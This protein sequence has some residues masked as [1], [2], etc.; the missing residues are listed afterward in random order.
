MIF[1]SIGT[2][3]D[4]TK[5]QPMEGKVAMKNRKVELGK[6]QSELNKRSRKIYVADI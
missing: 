6:Y 2:T 3:E 1:C 5:I 4:L